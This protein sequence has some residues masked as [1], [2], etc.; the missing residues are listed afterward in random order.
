LHNRQ[1]LRRAVLW[2]AGS[3]H[4]RAPRH[5]VRPQDARRGGIAIG[6]PRGHVRAAS[7]ASGALAEKDRDEWKERKAAAEQYRAREVRALAQ[8]V[9]ICRHNAVRESAHAEEYAGQV[10][11]ITAR[12]AHEE[13]KAARARDAAAALQADVDSRDRARA[14]AAKAAD[15]A[16][17]KLRELER[18]AASAGEREK[19]AQVRRF[20]H[21]SLLVARAPRSVSLRQ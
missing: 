10:A 9:T 7:S 8:R 12:V 4:S 19:H 16:G 11:E 20:A 1:A 15:K 21:C 2:H 13:A 17:R 5:R 3:S 18:G 6:T 14:A